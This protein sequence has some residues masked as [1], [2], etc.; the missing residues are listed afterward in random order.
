MTEASFGLARDKLVQLITDVEPFEPDWEG[1]RSINLSGKGAE[2]VIRLKDFLP[3]LE[4][5][6][7]FVSLS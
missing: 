2:T 7:L 5:L 3:G 4:N 6:D 1:L